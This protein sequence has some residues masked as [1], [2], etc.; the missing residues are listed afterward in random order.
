MI[1][2][3]IESYKS[4]T[5]RFGGLFPCRRVNLYLPYLKGGFRRAF[6]RQKDFTSFY[7]KFEHVSRRVAKKIIGLVRRVKYT[8]VFSRDKAKLDDIIQQ[9]L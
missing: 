3:I 1:S 2:K 7:Y 5:V 8:G 9:N 4:T 6:G